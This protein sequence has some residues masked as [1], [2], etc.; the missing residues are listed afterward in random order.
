MKVL[1]IE[2]F[3]GLRGPDTWSVDGNEGTVVVKTLIGEILAERTPSPEDIPHMY[4]EFAKRLQPGDC[5]LTFNYDVLLERAL[6]VVGNPYRLFPDRYEPARENGGRLVPSSG[7]EVVVLKFHGSIDWFDRREFSSHEEDC[8]KKFRNSYTPRH[9]VFSNAGALGVS[10]LL[11]GPRP[12]GDLLDQMYRVRDIKALYQKGL[13]FHAT[14]WLLAP[15][16]MK[17]LY[18]ER[19]KDFWY[20]LYRGGRLN[21][22]MAIIGYSLP[23]Q[24]EY[25]R[26]A[27]YML[28]RNYH[29]T[30]GWEKK[31]FERRKSPLVI[32]DYCPD[33]DRIRHFRERYGFV[34][35]C[36]ATLYADGLNDEAVDAIFHTE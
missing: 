13:M 2:H 31:V 32:V 15:S 26:Q 33:D 21:F 11:D 3:L 36:R 23:C 22:G 7:E 6:D 29:E 28:T 14:P 27:I 1:D 9:P 25:A 17:I 4:L 8:R 30:D 10:R 19:L 20:G 24:D 18:A 34:D 12:S 5:V 35:W 16:T